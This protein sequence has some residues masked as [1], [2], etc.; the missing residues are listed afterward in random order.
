MMTVSVGVYL[1]RAFL[2]QNSELVKISC[3]LQSALHLRE[4][5][6][7]APYRLILL[8]C[9]FCY[10]PIRPSRRCVYPAHRHFSSSA[11]A[12]VKGESSP[13]PADQ[14]GPSAVSP[15]IAPIV[16]TISTLT[17]VEVSELVTAL[18][19]S[20]SYLLLSFAPV[21]VVVLPEMCA[22]VVLG[23]TEYIRDCHAGS[24]RSSCRCT[25]HIRGCCRGE[26]ERKDNLYCEIGKDRCGSKSKGHPG[27]Q[28][29]HAQHELGGGMSSRSNLPHWSIHSHHLNI[30]PSV[31]NLRPAYRS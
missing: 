21:L 25:C 10:R 23:S 1:V 5:M 22:D 14:P 12:F 16:E 31:T 6:H 8:T 28:G 26:T 27:S 18:K 30:N 2:T 29:D 9:R 4:H 3:G 17:L 13:P 7:L 15:K 20:L 24:I 11:P 19:V